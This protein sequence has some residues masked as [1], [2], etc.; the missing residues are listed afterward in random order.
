[1]EQ[2]SENCEHKAKSDKRIAFLA[3]R[4]AVMLVILKSRH[5]DWD[6]LYGEAM[7]SDPEGM[8]EELRDWSEYKVAKDIVRLWLKKHDTREKGNG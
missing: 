2:C 3:D 6:W 5:G 4:M 1:M 7:W 8:A